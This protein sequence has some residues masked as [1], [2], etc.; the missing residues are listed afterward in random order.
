MFINLDLT[1]KGFV[2]NIEVLT[3]F[4]SVGNEVL[5]TSPGMTVEMKKTGAVAFRVFKD[6]KIL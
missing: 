1:V 6:L 4:L 3:C 2:D 5:M